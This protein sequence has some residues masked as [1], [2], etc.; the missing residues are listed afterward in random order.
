ML[1]L[2]L[3][4]T[5][6]GISGYALFHAF[7]AIPKLQKWESQSQRAAKYSNTAAAQLERTKATE[8]VGVLAVS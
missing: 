2:L 8:T 5:E 4:L 6:S 1:K 7:N 3:H